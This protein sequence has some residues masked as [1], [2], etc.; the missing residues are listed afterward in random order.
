MVYFSGPMPGNWLGLPSKVLNTQAFPPDQCFLTRTPTGTAGGPDPSAARTDVKPT[1]PSTEASIITGADRTR[2]QTFRDGF[3]TSG[4]KILGNPICTTSPQI[5]KMSRK[6]PRGEYIETDTGNKVARKATLVGTQ[7]IMLGGKTVIQQEVMIRGDLIRSLPSSSSS[8]GGP[9][10]NTAVAIGRYC[11]L[12]RGCCLKPPGR[13]YKGVFTYM[14][15]RMGDH[16]FV[17]QNT[18]VQAAQIGSH[19]NIGAQVVVGEFAIIKDFVRIL[20]GSVVPANMV[21][22]SF[23]IVAGQPAKVI[24]EVPEGGHDA[25][26]LRDLYKSVGNNPQPAPS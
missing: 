7:N 15:L 25:F 8:G 16:V 10:S 1:E 2:A 3:A 14:P 23:S 4:L 20:D 9:P 13:L 17:G 12:S 21:I 22:P 5:A 26:E 19:V 18:V 6:P 11:F 24:G